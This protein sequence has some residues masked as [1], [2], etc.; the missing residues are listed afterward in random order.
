MT[1]L[2]R[3]A[4]RLLPL[5]LLFVFC[6]SCDGFFVSNSSIQS[7][8]VTPT[9]VILAV[10]S[11]GTPA[12]T[13]SLKS[14]ANTV[15]GTTTDDTATANWTSS[16]PSVVTVNAGKLTS[17]ATTGGSQAIITATDSGQSSTATVLTYTGAPPAALSV[18]LPNGLVPAG[19]T[20]SLIFALT[21]VATVNGNTSFNISNFVSWTSSNTSAATVNA[22][23]V[24]TVLSTATAGTQFTITATA[25]LGD[26]ATTPTVS[27]TSGTFTLI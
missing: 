5:L 2:L 23:G 11:A 24:V 16:A 8:A 6:T 22:I 10:A 3:R 25:F 17:V 14:S 13:F 20:P 26:A 18:N 9:S 12:D 27:G 15:G 19:I 4:V 7:I 21:A 1:L